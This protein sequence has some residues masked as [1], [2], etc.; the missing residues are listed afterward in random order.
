MKRFIP[1]A[2]K[3]SL[4]ERLRSALGASF[5]I[6][7]IYLVGLLF[8][9]ID[10]LSLWVV[11]SIG[12][13]AFLIFV[14]PSSPMAHPFAV[15][16][17]NIIS[18][19]IAITCIR[20]IEIPILSIVISVAL[21]VVL[22]FYLRCL[23]PPAASLCLLIPIAGMDQYQFSLLPVLTNSILLV[24]F[25]TTFNRFTK[26]S[27]P[28]SLNNKIDSQLLELQI[29][30]VLDRYNEVIDINKD[31]LAQLI[32]Q[33]EHR[34]YQKRLEAMKC[35]DIMSRDVFSIEMHST[36]EEAWMILRN[37][38]IKAL[39][40]VDKGRRVLG[41]ITL[42]DFIQS[43]SVDFH[44]AF[45]QRIRGFL[46]GTISSLSSPPNAVGQVM[47][48]R[49]RVISEDRNVLDLAEIF[50]GNGHHHIPVI[51]S[52]QV[53]VGMITQSDFVKAIDVSISIKL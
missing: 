48:K 44:Q 18:A 30:E 11:A 22:M 10:H 14:V 51:N 27:S 13:S 53:L 36:L 3:V 7:F 29:N 6:L 52:N 40:V 50:C 1:E 8:H 24:I 23:H 12:A 5:S 45:G 47:T 19:L 20:Y 42:E 15:I 32:S 25:A 17:G 37:Q 33:V 39:P 46:R 16:F 38:H 43:A 49:V 34:A 35:K 28:Q 26:K 2:S 41:I 21:S 9:Q 4:L 31:D